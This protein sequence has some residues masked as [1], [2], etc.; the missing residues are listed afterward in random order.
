MLLARALLLPFGFLITLLQ[1]RVFGLQGH[2]VNEPYMEPILKF[3]DD[4]SQSD[5]GLP[6]GPRHFVHFLYVIALFSICATAPFGK[7]VPLDA[8]FADDSSSLTQE[9]CLVFFSDVG[10][11]SFSPACRSVFIC[12]STGSWWS[13]AEPTSRSCVNHSLP[14]LWPCLVL[15]VWRACPS[16]SRKIQHSASPNATVMLTTSSPNPPIFLL[17]RDIARCTT[18]R[19]IVRLMLLMTSSWAPLSRHLSS[20]ETL[21]SS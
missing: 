7:S 19:A 11:L 20:T 3:N 16:G 1:Q 15:E 12:L 21:D 4:L 9:S 14:T 2:I 10:F 8:P 17:A 5:R 18:K 13:F 6:D